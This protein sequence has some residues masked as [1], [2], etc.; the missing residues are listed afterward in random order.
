MILS[1][2]KQTILIVIIHRLLAITA[3]PGFVY[4]FNNSS[5]WL[6]YSRLWTCDI[7]IAITKW[8]YFLIQIPFKPL[9]SLTTYHH[10]R[11]DKDS[12]GI[13]FVKEYCD[14]LEK[15]FRLLKKRVVIDS[16]MPSE[17]EF[18][19]SSSFHAPSPCNNCIS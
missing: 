8:S 7:F 14:S 2:N 17:K 5:F 1:P 15:E 11:A 3:F 6:W 4:V 9:S 10:F 18:L 12:P 19:H 16:S 13:V